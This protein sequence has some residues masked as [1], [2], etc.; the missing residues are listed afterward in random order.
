M[1]GRKMAGFRWLCVVG[2]T[3]ALTLSGCSALPTSTPP[4]EITA[5]FENIAGMYEGNEIMVLGLAVGTV[6]KIV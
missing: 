2:G 4:T 5:D 1:L 3:A 6:D